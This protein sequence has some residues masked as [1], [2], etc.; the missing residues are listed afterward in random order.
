MWPSVPGEERLLTGYLLGNLTEEKMAEVEDRAFADNAYR[1]TLEAAEADLIDSYV[2]GELA[3]PELR[4]FE[5]RFLAS[6]QRRRK[7]EFA[8]TLARVAD[9]EAPIAEPRPSPW[10]SLLEWG[11]P[12]QFVSA[13]AMLIAAAGVSLLTIQNREMRTR[14]AELEVRGSELQQK[15]RVLDSQLAEE[16]ARSSS[17]AAQAK[18][19]SPQAL[20]AS[21]VLLPGSSRGS[22]SAGRLSLSSDAQLARIEIQLEAADEFPRFR[23]ELRTVGGAEVLTQGNLRGRRNGSGLS[24]SLDVPASALPVG[25]YELALKGVPAENSVRDI[26]YYYFQV[27]RN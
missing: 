15:T 7:I 18:Q 4:S 16:K 10:R 6:P 22:S 26:G 24:V 3:G 27:Q 14:V 20:I 11:R 5:Q 1:L 21:L 12:L 19:A 8:R 2:R 17:L 9:E 25:Q 23:A 13:M